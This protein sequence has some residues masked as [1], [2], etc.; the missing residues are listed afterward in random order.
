MQ[1]LI[2]AIKDWYYPVMTPSWN[3]MQCHRDKTSLTSRL[4]ADP[5]Q[6]PRVILPLRCFSFPGDNLRSLSGP[7]IAWCQQTRTNHDHFFKVYSIRLWWWKDIW[8]CLLICVFAVIE[9]PLCN[10]ACFVWW[11]RLSWISLVARTGKSHWLAP[12]SLQPLLRSD[13]I[14]SPADTSAHALSAG[15]SGDTN[16]WCQVE[17]PM[18]AETMAHLLSSPTASSP[19]NPRTVR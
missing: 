18:K 10:G 13:S 19:I 11:L 6:C 5:V 8:I 12:S 14:A 3:I 4:W 9:Q 2:Y 15:G 17:H 7:G 16:H 1:I